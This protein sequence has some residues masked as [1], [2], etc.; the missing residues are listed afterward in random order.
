M[1]KLLFSICI[2]MGS[3]IQLHAT[4]TFNKALF[5][6]AK[7]EHKI[8]I[9]DLEAVWC[10]W[11]HVMDKTTY[12]NKE[13]QALID[14]HFLFVKVDHDL[15]PDL[16]QRYREYGWPAT[17][18]FD[19]DGNEIVKRSGYIKPD[20]MVALLKRIIADSSVGAEEVQSNA[21]YTSSVL[22]DELKEV[23]ENRHNDSYDTKLGGLDMFQ[24]YLEEDS[25]LYAMQEASCG[26]KLE[27]A[28]AKQT[29]DAA[30]KL[31]DPVWGGAYQYSTHRDWDHAHYEKI[32]S[33][34][35]RY[36]KIY[37][38][39]AKQFKSEVY[40]NA[41]KRV[42][43]YVLRFLRDEEN[44]AFYVSQDADI[45]Q[46]EK[47]HAYFKYDDKKR[48]SL[49]IPKIDT[50]LYA[51]SQGQMIEALA[52]LYEASNEKKYLDDAKKSAQWTLENRFVNGGGFSHDSNDAVLYLN[53]NLSMGKGFLALYRVA[54]EEHWLK[55]ASK[56]GFF[57]ERYFKAPEAGVLT[58]T[59]NG[60]PIKPVR[61]LDENIHTAL[62]MNALGHDTGKSKHSIF[63][64]HIM[65]YIVN[66]SVALS[67]FTEA[68]ILICDYE[69]KH[70]VR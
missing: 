21:T 50:H 8:I 34:Q 31:I 36:I 37:A 59:D 20:D 1:K 54:G 32:I 10:H 5:E 51:S 60:T 6:K 38:L 11:C 9:M 47:A 66:R 39:A 45:K 23:L 12:T 29:L 44:G 26:N 70:N 46:G 17:I 53:D 62:F 49:G 43:D 35:S 19:G 24:K 33:I 52:Y 4:N 58:A 25:V 2:L 13:V 16:A 57:L 67:R 27:E 7:K 40:L 15:R 68:G 3:S 56:L 42:A 65:R 30:M 61:Q 41:S 63:A 28:R 64:K 18:F 55:Q 14:K 22:Q 48:L 69:F